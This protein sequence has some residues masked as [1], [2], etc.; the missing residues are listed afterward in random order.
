MNEKVVP[1]NARLN[2]QKST[3]KKSKVNYT[4]LEEYK[5]GKI[6]DEDYAFITHYIQLQNSAASEKYRKV[7]EQNGIDVSKLP[8]TDGF[9][10]KQAV[11][12]VAPKNPSFTFIDLF[13][14]IG[15]FRLAMQSCGGQCVFSSEWDDAAKQTYFENYGEV[16]FGDITKI[17]SSDIPDFDIL[18]GGF[19]C[20]PFSSI[21]KREGFQ[22]KT[23]GTLFFY[24]ANIIKEK[25][26]KAFLLENVTGLLTHDNGQT[27]QTI[28]DTLRNELEYNVETKVLNSADFEVPQERKRLYFVGFRKDIFDKN[29]VFPTGS[30]N[31]VGFGQFVEKNAEG[32]SISEHLQ[33]S[34]I[35]KKDDGHPEIVDEN[36]DFPVKTFCASYH[37][38][39]RI[40][41][42]FVR[43]GKTGLRLFTESECKSVMGFPKNFKCP[44]SRTQKYH[45]FGNSV[46]VP[47]VTAISKEI[48]K[49]INQGDN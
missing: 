5:N 19:P 1:K 42:T 15:G 20:Q 32:P 48:V 10:T 21:G 16:P 37:K 26:P 36:T 9:N 40:T 7:L 13:A 8:A 44:V 29:F 22:H 41:G 43:G 27:Y 30:K 46:A 47:V 18:T 35:F 28:L 39:Q 12:F 4:V 25:K 34:Y 33:R 6:F 31:K 49:K 17:K 45:Q 23:Q 11:P 2:E 24:I 3:R 14:G 38:I